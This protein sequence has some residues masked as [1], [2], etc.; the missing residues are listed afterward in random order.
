MKEK[1][2]REK[3]NLPV[4]ANVTYIDLDAQRTTPVIT[5]GWTD[6]QIKNKDLSELDGMISSAQAGLDSLRETVRA[7]EDRLADLIL[8]RGRKVSLGG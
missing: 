4:G 7:E 1:E 6:E 8:L 2:F 3:Y 5:A